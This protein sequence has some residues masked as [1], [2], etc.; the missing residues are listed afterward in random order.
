MLAS[1]SP[2]CSSSRTENPRFA[3]SHAIVAPPPP[4]PTTMKSR[5]AISL[6]RRL[7]SDAE[8]CAQGGPRTFDIVYAVHV[9]D[10]PSFSEFGENGALPRVRRSGRPQVEHAP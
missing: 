5:L 9:S 10:A 2:P 6:L 3:R 1:G 4:L 8:R 7:K